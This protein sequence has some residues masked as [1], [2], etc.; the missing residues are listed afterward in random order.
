MKKILLLSLACVVLAS[1]VTHVQADL[2]WRIRPAVTGVVLDSATRKPLEGVYVL[3]EYTESGANLF[4][5]SA[6]WCIRTAGVHTD[7]VGGFK[8]PPGPNGVPILR[9]IKLG[10]Q[11]D[12]RTTINEQRRRG[13]SDKSKIEY[14]ARQDSGVFRST[15]YF[16]CTRAKSAPDVSANLVYLKYL[17]AEYQRYI[18]DSPFQDVIRGAV[19]SLENLPTNPTDSTISK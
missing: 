7:K 4:A 6:S 9:F 13:E 14:M 1:A 2:F 18:P 3:A 8:F 15:Q 5:H 11:S 10:Y 19:E 16:K 17:S 12:T